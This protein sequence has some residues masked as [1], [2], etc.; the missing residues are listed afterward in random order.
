M[1]PRSSVCANRS[2][3]RTIGGTSREDGQAFEPGAV[4]REVARQFDV[5]SSLIY[6][7]RRDLRAVANDFAR[8]LVAPAGDRE[9][10]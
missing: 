4:V 6:R 9:T 5:T 10:G 1:S 2:R 8:V 3:W 7:W